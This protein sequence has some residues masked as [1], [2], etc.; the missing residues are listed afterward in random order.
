VDS[1]DAHFESWRRLGAEVGVAFSEA[2]FRETF[3][4]TSR[5]ILRACFADVQGGLSNER[6]GDLDD[7]KESLYRDIIAASFPAMPGAAAL[8]DDL[9]AAG[10]RLAVGSSG[11]PQNVA[12]VLDRL[13]RAGAFDARVTGDDV[14]R[15]KPDPQV[16]TLAAERLDVP[17]TRC[18]VI[19]DAPAGV[20]A[21]RR[22]GMAAVA[23]LSTGRGR[24]DFLESGPHRVVESL[25]ELTPA[26]IASLIEG[27]A[28]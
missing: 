15:G 24:D 7:R 12:L 3:G 25:T 13:D 26:A 27:A 17:P 23:L 2:Q 1:Y 5:D 22:A 14:T 20:E 28:G 16:F 4:R 10:F 11:P 21:A 9:V 19:E 8:I 6:I 18:V